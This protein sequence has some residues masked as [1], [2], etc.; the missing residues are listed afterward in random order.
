MNWLHAAVAAFAGVLGSFIAWHHPLSPLL[1]CGAFLAWSAAVWLRPAIWPFVVPA[2]LPLAGLAPW[3]GWIGVEEFDL[4][5]LGAVT[6][7]HGRMAATLHRQRPDRQPAASRQQRWFA[8]AEIGLA[9][10][11]G[12]WLLALVRGLV[13]AV[14]VGGGA[15]EFALG[16]FAAYE[17]P[18]NSLRVGKSLP[19]MLLLLPSLRRP[20]R[21]APELLTHRLAA[22]IASG[23]AIASL[24]ILQ[25]RAAYPG[26]FDFSTA[27]RTTALFWE[28]HVG[29]AALDGFLALTVPF[30]VYALRRA[31]D[32]WRWA[33]AAALALIAAY[34][35]LTSFSRGVY[36]AVAIALSVLACRFF[37]AAVG[38]PRTACTAS[39]RRSQPW[40][41]W[42]GRALVVLLIIEVVA[43]LGL[44]DFMGRRLSG[45]V[46]DLGGRLQHW[47]EGLQLL[48]APSEIVFGRGLGRFPANYS[49]AV[50]ERE[51]AG[52]LRVID[53]DGRDQRRYLRLFGPH[54]SAYLRGAFDLLQRVPAMAGGVYT[55]H[56]ELRAAQSAR[57]LVELC[58]RHLLYA[59]PC[60]RVVVL[61]IKGDEQWQ[62]WS[63]ALTAAGGSTDWW[64]PPGPGFLTIRLLGPAAFVDIDKLSVVGS[65]GREWLRNG[66]FSDGLRHWFFAGH[67]YFVP[68]HIDNLFLEMLID[69]G[70]VGLV[71]L[72]ALL[73]LAFANLL[74]GPGR[75]QVL[76]PYL[77]ASLLAGLAVGVFSSLL[78]MPRTAFLFFLLLC[79]A[80]FLDGT[81]SEALPGTSVGPQERA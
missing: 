39:P 54:H 33:L 35:C 49:Q 73:A 46:R 80:L 53:E 21:S 16:W 6:G 3:T 9:L 77:L 44:G 45:G 51:L 34:A 28:M 59:M 55:V 61:P 68:W 58:P 47:S 57:L 26:L 23:L 50:P 11:A 14:S 29:G 12:S 36:L 22:G 71:L 74:Y 13:D 41:L 64:P 69:Q 19:L 10:L 31:P 76:A 56:I 72:L 48:R 81:S 43:V 40:R 4:L 32:P 63:L 27:Y 5:L 38:G 79:S 20:L 70:A 17:E 67:D 1:L 30:V 75:T 8:L 66:S 15:G 42:G 24:A 18:L 65:D 37:L 2:L 78:D 7:C 62:G 52:H 25:E 60:S